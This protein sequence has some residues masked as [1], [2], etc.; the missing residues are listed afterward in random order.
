MFCGIDVSKNKSSVCIIDKDK[1]VLHEFGINHDRAGFEELEKHLT[2]KIRVGMESTGVYSKALYH[3]LKRKHDVFYVNSYQMHT[4]C[5]LHN[6]TIKNDKADARLIAEYVS[7]GMKE[8]HLQDSN[9]MKELSRLYFKVTKQLTKQ[10]Y[11]FKSELNVV[12]PELESHF[13]TLKV[14][15]IP[16]MLLKYPTPKDI[17]EAT[18]KELYQSLRASPKSNPRFGMKKVQR[19][20]ELAKDSIGVSNY[21][22]DYFKYTIK[23][24][25]FYQ[26]LSEDLVERM[27]KEIDK[28]PY[29]KLL[30]EFGY[31]TRSLATIIGEIGDI[32]RF[33]NYKK[34][35]KFIGLDITEERSGSSINRQSYISKRGNR[36]LRSL[37]YNMV[38]PHLSYK[39]P[40]SKFFYKLRDQKG[41]H[42]KKA[43]I[44]TSRKLAIKCYFDMKQCHN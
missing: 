28:T 5:E 38:L 13:S 44:A 41:K 1:K 26:D 15:S 2:P 23:L 35:V 7:Q 4:F 3:Y 33:G 17:A 22:A 19:I 30:G 20:K 18:D 36:Q 25:L 9:V 27:E 12:F 29:K 14:R 39:T 37:F 11:M 16:N 40:H 42:P 21:P 43:M 34:L 32:R 8:V 31:S 6:P 24:L 10:K